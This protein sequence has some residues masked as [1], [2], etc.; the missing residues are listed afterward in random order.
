MLGHD[1]SQESGKYPP[2]VRR[3]N[4]EDLVVISPS[5]LRNINEAVAAHISTQLLKWNE[6]LEG[7][8]LGFRKL[9]VIGDRGQIYDDVPDVVV[10][11]RCQAYVFSPK[12]GDELLGRV[13]DFYSSHLSLLVCDYYN[14]V[15]FP[16]DVNRALIEILPNDQG[17]RDKGAKRKLEIGD[18]VI[19]RVK[20]INYSS[21]GMVTINGA[22]DKIPC[23]LP[24]TVLSESLAK[25]YLAVSTL[26]AKS[27]E[28]VG[29]V[30]L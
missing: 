9:E 4:F 26:I 2:F 23:G 27:L 30:L 24:S 21:D 1:Q 20:D 25:S 18:E 11:V 8:F 12:P 19:F 5:K 6:S 7:G 17:W 13:T 22:F 14:V 29:K 3:V 16:E 15:V 10:P 28:R